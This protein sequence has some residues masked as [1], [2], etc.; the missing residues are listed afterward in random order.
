MKLVSWN[1]TGLRACL[2][3]GFAESMAA[4]D[5]DVICLQETKMEPH[6][7]DVPLEGYEVLYNSAEKKGYSGTAV[8]SRKPFLSYTTGIGIEEHDHEG[9]VITV[10][11]PDFY[12][13]NCYTPNAQ[14][15]LARLD[16]RMRW[17]EDFQA[18]LAALDAQ[19]PDAIPSTKGVL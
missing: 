13:V 2:G 15:E 11:Y 14:R 6:Q 7:A 4:L 8:F 16:Y 9:R 3:K 18:Y 5:A 10:E 17:E 19:N 12:L 1:V